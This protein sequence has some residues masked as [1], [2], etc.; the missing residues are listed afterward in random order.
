MK[1]LYQT[2][3]AMTVPVL[4]LAGCSTDELDIEQHGAITTSQYETADDDGVKSLIAAIYANWHGDATITNGISGVKGEGNYRYLCTTL[5]SMSD[6]NA[7]VYKYMDG[8]EGLLYRQFWEYFYRNCYWCNMLLTYLPD[9]QTCTPS[10]KTRVL[11]E[12]RAM[13]AINMMYIV[14]LYGNAPLADHILQGN[15]ANTPAEQSW[16]FIDSE[17]AAAAEE[18]PSKQDLNGQMAIGGRLTKEAAYAYL[19]KAY[20]W[21]G[22]Y[23]EAAQTLYNKVIAT[24][25]YALVSDFDSLNS[26]ANDFSPENIFEF[27]F[28]DS[29]DNAS[30]QEGAFD[31]IAFGVFNNWTKTYA[32]PMMHYDYGRKFTKSF[33]DFMQAHD[34]ENSARYKGTLMEYYDLQENNMVSSLNYPAV[35]CMGYINVKYLCRTEDMVGNS[36]LNYC[37]A[38]YVYMRYAEVLLNYAEAVAMG[39]SAGA[40]SGLEALN[41]VR[42]RAGLADAPVLDMENSDYGIKAERRAELVEEGCRWIDLVRWGDAPTVLKDVGKTSYTLQ[43]MNG[44]GSY[45]VLET[46]TGGP[47]FI[48]GKN[49]LFPIP[50]SDLNENKNLVQNTN[51]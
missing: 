16:E 23:D 10:L 41:L 44:K 17:L 6:E 42:E 21:Q 2:I 45:N 11:A 27:N 4:L 32:N 18:L 40:M 5:G 30:S 34:G 33:Y 46:S 43:S 28:D 12:A 9:N 15:E 29:G 26:S 14:Q 22:K 19:G 51:W 20:L 37:K 50:Q 13:R 36:P 47:G 24:G 35:D 31:V 48:K 25:L 1:S 49:E 3:L 39:G 38:N 8:S 7:D